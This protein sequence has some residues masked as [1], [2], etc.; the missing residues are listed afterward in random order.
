MTLAPELPG[1]LVLIDQ[2]TERGVVV[3]LGH[4]D[5][6]AAQASAA[7]DRGARSVTHVFN[8]M[9]P[10]LHRDPGIIGGS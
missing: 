2:L 9:R 10:L 7:F 4:S 3:S 5:A 1:G 6:T 8:A